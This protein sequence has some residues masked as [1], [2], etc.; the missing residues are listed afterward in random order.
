M[1][2]SL[3]TIC[4]QKLTDVGLVLTGFFNWN[5]YESKDMRYYK[6]KIMNSISEPDIVGRDALIE[7]FYADVFID[8]RTDKESE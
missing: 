3:L 4:L 6:V 2:R 1:D 8:D 7:T 5:A